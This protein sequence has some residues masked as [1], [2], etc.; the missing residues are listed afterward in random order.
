[1]RDI[2]DAAPACYCSQCRGEIYD[3]D[4]CYV[5]DDIIYC[6]DCIDAFRFEGWEVADE[7]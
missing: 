7:R 1:M 6:E 3:N 4:V 5:I 2:Q